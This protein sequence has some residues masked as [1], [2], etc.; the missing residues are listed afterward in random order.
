M[1]RVAFLIESNKQRIGCL[2]NPEDLVIRRRAGVSERQS[3]GGIVTGADLFDDQL[4]YSGG[5]STSLILN[6]LFDVNLPGSSI[7]T[8]DVRELTHPIWMLSENAPS[9]KTAQYGRPPLFRLFWG[10]TLN[11]PGVVT[12]IAERLEYFSA[13]GVPKRSWLRLKMQRV[14]E[15]PSIKANAP[16]TVLGSEQFTGSAT[17]SSVLNGAHA[18]L[19]DG[20]SSER[21]DS[22]ASRFYGNPSLWRELASINNIPN[23][24]DIAPG[25]V[26]D[27]PSVSDIGV[28][29]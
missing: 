9:K 15:T 29:T 16:N 18:V 22:I 14:I 4:L 11:I 27:L 25:K 8:D 12:A 2:L 13:T 24:A 1:E 28:N 23:P 20:E 7:N 17:E 6:L 26:I 5:G 3:A 21:L 19:S 10:K